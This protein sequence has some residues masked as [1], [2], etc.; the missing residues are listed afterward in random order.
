MLGK[1]FAVSLPHQIFDLM[2]F[3]RSTTFS[4]VKKMACLKECSG[5]ALPLPAPAAAAIVKGAAAAP[6]WS[7]NSNDND[8]PDH[9]LRFLFAFLRK[10]VRALY[11]NIIFITISTNLTQF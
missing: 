2:T 11:C 1:V 4:S 10:K 5:A 7:R 8:R 3:A 6:V 9:P